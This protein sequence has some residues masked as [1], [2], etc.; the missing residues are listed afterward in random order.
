MSQISSKTQSIIP[1]KYVAKG[2]PWTFD[3]LYTEYSRFHFEDSNILVHIIFVPIL[4]LSIHGLTMHF[5][6]MHPVKIDMTNPNELPVLSFGM[7]DYLP[8]QENVFVM[9][10][11]IPIILGSGAVLV[12][13]DILIGALTLS[14]IFTVYQVAKM[15]NTEAMK[16][17]DHPLH[18]WVLKFFIIVQVGGWAT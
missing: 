9:S 6:Q 3:N 12:Y 7:H 2:N 1:K 16:N 14:W 10:Y 4:M 18:G 8:V 13:A 17:P 15:T 11:W 5:P